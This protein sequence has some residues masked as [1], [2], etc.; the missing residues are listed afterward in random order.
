M[1]DRNNRH[2][3]GRRRRCSDFSASSHSPLITETGTHLVGVETLKHVA[4]PQ[5][6]AQNGGKRPVTKEPAG[7]RLAGPG[8]CPAAPRPTRGLPSGGGPRTPCTLPAAGAK[9]PGQRA[10]G[11]GSTASPSRRPDRPRLPRAGSGRLHPDLPNL[12]RA[13]RA[14]RFLEFVTL[15]LA[16]NDSRCRGPI[17]GVNDHTRQLLGSIWAQ[18]LGA[19]RG[20]GLQ[21]PL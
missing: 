3:S 8:V 4:S 15:S 13:V 16:L 11:P 21:D 7:D 9:P 20:A 17:L 6:G 2:V 1:L 19:E 10:G 12:P 5:H 18:G 14:S